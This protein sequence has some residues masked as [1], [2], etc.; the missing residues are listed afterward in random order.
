MP[1]R[2]FGF[3]RLGIK[4]G[5]PR[6]SSLRVRHGELQIWDP[7][8]VGMYYIGLQLAIAGVRLASPR[9][10][11]IKSEMRYLHDSGAL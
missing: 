2:D 3:H 10:R 1:Q 9:R 4:R 7:S 5:V 11:W 8:G 6:Q